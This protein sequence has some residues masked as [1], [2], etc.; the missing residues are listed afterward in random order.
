MPALSLLSPKRTGAEALRD[1]GIGHV[2]VLAD[3]SAQW[4]IGGLDQWER[5][6][7]NLEEGTGETV[8]D[9]SGNGHDGTI[10][11]AEWVRLVP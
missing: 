8:K 7:L 4:R 3:E 9:E 10:H 11:G 6:L 5:I 2:V 1:L